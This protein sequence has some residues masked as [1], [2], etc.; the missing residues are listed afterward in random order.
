MSHINL[1]KFNFDFP[2]IFKRY[3]AVFLI[4][5]QNVIPTLSRLKKDRYEPTPKSFSSLHWR[6]SYFLR[7][8]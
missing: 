2:N 3:P 7:G 8:S 6:Q 1:L 5:V 4:E